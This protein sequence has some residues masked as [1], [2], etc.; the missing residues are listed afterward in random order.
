MK[1]TTRLAL[2]AAL[3]LAGLAAQAL[4]LLRPGQDTAVTGQL[5]CVDG[6]FTAR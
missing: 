4:T 2:V 6:G 5:V 1:T 3:S